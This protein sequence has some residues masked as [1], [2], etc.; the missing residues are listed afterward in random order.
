MIC[1]RVMIRFIGTVIVRFRIRVSSGT[2]NIRVMV[3]FRVM[4]RVKGTVRVRIGIRV[5][6][7]FSGT[8]S[9]R[10]HSNIT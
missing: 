2:I 9:V 4:V 3:R 10:G 6:V 7:M 8:V 1:V 5:M